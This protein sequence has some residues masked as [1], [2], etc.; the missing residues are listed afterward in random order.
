MIPNRHCQLELPMMIITEAGIK[1]GLHLSYR[2]CPRV[3]GVFIT[4]SASGKPPTWW[5]PPCNA[6]TGFCTMEFAGTTNVMVK[7]AFQV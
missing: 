2:G 1:G 3:E 6:P 5:V 7:R 4:A